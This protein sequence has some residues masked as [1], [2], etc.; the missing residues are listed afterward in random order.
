MTWAAKNIALGVTTNKVRFHIDYCA[1]AIPAILS[2]ACLRDKMVLHVGEAAKISTISVAGTH[3][4][5]DNRIFFSRDPVAMDRLGLDILEDKRRDTGLGV[6]PLHRRPRRVLRRRG[7]WDGRS[8][9]DRPA[10]T[11][12][13]G[14]AP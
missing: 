1:R 6:R 11:A 8:L 2:H 10:G 3:L 4:A 9:A 7:P 13:L 12:G 14:P 5:T